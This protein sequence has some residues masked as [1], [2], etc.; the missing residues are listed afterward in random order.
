MATRDL[1]AKAPERAEKLDAAMLERMVRGEFGLAGRLHA[2]RVGA[3]LTVDQLGVPHARA[4]EQGQV[5]PGIVDVRRI[6]ART[7][8]DLA[9]LLAA[10]DSEVPGGD[11]MRMEEGRVMVAEAV[12]STEG[13]PCPCCGQFV[14]AREVSLS[15]KIGAVV[16][17][18]T[19]DFRGEP[20]R[21]LIADVARAARDA[22]LWDLVL[23]VGGEAFMP[24]EAGRTFLRG[25]L[26]LPRRLIVWQGKIIGQAGK[27][28]SWVDLKVPDE[29]APEALALAL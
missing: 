29:A 2:A 5:R 7:G 14:K 21:L 10:W 9:G 27:P 4:Y 19:R 28:T 12:K 23:P 11:R 6:A 18:V 16:R 24:T 3:G 15:A 8:A 13:G 26:S 25:E 20:V 22:A 17:G 1:F